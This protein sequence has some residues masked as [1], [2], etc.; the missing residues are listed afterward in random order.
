VT[1]FEGRSLV[2]LNEPLICFEPDI[3]DWLLAS[4]ISR[5][6]TQHAVNERKVLGGGVSENSPAH[7][8]SGKYDESFRFR[9]LA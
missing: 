2:G 6:P 4:W 7:R 5:R 1:G 9:F 3:R 8:I